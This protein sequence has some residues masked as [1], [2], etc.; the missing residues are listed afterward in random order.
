MFC[1]NADQSVLLKFKGLLGVMN[2]ILSSLFGREKQIL[3]AL[4]SLSMFMV[5]IVP[6]EFKLCSLS[7]LSIRPMSKNELLLRVCRGICAF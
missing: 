6:S 5:G 2:S 7:L 3:M 4:W 1:W